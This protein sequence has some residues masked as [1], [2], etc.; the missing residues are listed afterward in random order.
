MGPMT[1]YTYSIKD[2]VATNMRSIIMTAIIT[3]NMV[4]SVLTLAFILLVSIIV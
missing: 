2:S 3:I 4:T 1:V